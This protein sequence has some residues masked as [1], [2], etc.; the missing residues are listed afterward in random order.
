MKPTILAGATAIVLGALSGVPTALAGE[1]PSKPGANVYIVSPSHGQ[2]VGGS[3]KVV[4]GLDGMGVAPAGIEKDG[5]GHHH[6]MVNMDAS[7]V[8]MDA[9][10]PADDNHIHFGGGQ[11]ETILNLAPGEHTLQLVLADHNHIPH[12]P[13]V[14]SEK[15]TIT[16]AE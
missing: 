9:P 11:T 4:F 16:V 12:N 15:I 5:T 14:I 1:T 13:P 6:L 10:L 2:T 8:D 7:T 3:V